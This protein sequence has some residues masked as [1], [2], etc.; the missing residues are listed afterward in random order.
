MKNLFLGGCLLIAPLIPATADNTQSF[1]QPGD[2]VVICGDSITEMAVY[3]ADIE[4]YLL[5]CQPGPKPHVFLAGLVGE[6]APSFVMRMDADALPFKPTVATVCY[7]MN[8]GHYKPPDPKAADTYKTALGQI[9][10]KFKQAGLRQIIVGTPGVVDTETFKTNGMGAVGATVY[11]QTLGGLA[12]AAK[13][14]ATDKAVGF[15][16]LHDPMM[17]VM[18]QAKAKY[19]VDYQFEGHDGVHPGPTGSLVMAYCFLKAMGFDGNIGTITFDMASNQATATDGHKIVSAQNG[20]IKVESSRYPFCFN[21]NSN[22]ITSPEN[23]TDV[24][25]IQP[26]L[27]FLPFNQDLNRFMLVVKNAPSKMLK[28]TWGK[29]TKEF[30]AADLEKGVNLAAEF[31]DNPFSHAFGA[32]HGLVEK[33][34]L[35][36]TGCRVLNHANPAWISMFPE[37]E[38]DIKQLEAALYKKF[39][40]LSSQAADAATP[41]THTIQVTAE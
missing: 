28:V 15:A 18:G 38:P 16:D 13:A 11:N 31:L 24:K 19:G 40:D 27:E 8:D 32:V 39:D 10:D 22:G 33:Q 7:G 1:L 14:V 21:V 29:E 9:V 36:N 23:S 12:D 3:S 6:T 26:I 2:R 20:A 4:D 30:A 37:S 34:Q 5:M 41:V 25:A 17:Q 35:F